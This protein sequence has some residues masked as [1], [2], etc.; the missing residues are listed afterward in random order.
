MG[1]RAGDDLDGR[2]TSA[3]RAALF[4]SR[5]LCGNGVKDSVDDVTD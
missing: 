3:G 1:I 5:A 4:S 2:L